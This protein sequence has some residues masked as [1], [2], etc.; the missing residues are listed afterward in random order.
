MAARKA[1]SSLLQVVAP[2][3]KLAGTAP[4]PYETIVPED[5]YDVVFVS[6]ERFAWHH[7]KKWAV[8]M[9]IVEGPHLGKLLFFFLPIPPFRKR[10]TP[11]AKMSRSYERA[12]GLRAPGRIAAH[13]PSWFLEG[14][15]FTVEVRTVT[16]DVDGST[17][18]AATRY[19]VVHKIVERVAGAPPCLGRRKH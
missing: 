19:S 9:K 10:R 4:D 2:G 17:R 13:R 1:T 3:R 12:T 5:R 6:E 18:P 11:S 7:G 16:S 15:V 14:A 8:V